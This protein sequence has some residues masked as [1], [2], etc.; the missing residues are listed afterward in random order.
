MSIMGYLSMMFVLWTIL[1]EWAIRHIVLVFPMV[2]RFV[3]CTMIPIENKEDTIEEI[4]LET[5]IE[6]YVV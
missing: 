4:V 3:H 5:I 2:S 6:E 1:S